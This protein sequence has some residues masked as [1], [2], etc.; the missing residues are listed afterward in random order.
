M[1]HLIRGLKF[2][3]VKSYGTGQKSPPQK[4]KY[5]PPIFYA[6]GF[7]WATTFFQRKCTVFKALQAALVQAQLPKPAKCSQNACRAANLQ[8]AS[9]AVN[10]GFLTTDL[11]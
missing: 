5:S 9:L 7:L 4:P 3:K 2:P 10:R 8:L 6:A 1:E 11:G